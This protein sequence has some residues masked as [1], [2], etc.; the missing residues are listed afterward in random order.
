MITLYNK[1]VPL[2]IRYKADICIILLKDL[3][4]ELR[5]S[6]YNLDI[7][8]VLLDVIQPEVWFDE[9]PDYYKRHDVLRKTCIELYD[10]YKRV[11]SF[12]KI[13]LFYEPIL[14]GIVS[15]KL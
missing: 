7:N 8:L 1:D 12:G 4:Q 9:I 5:N 14:K 2:D 13:F 15:S 10:Y 6:G 3:A 11:D